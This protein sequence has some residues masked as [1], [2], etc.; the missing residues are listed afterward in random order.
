MASTPIRENLIQ[1]LSHSDESTR[2]ARMERIEWLAQHD[3][4]P[5]AYF[6]AVDT[7]SLVDEARTCFIYGLFVATV[8]LATS[9]VEHAL[10]DELNEQGLI[11]GR[12]TLDQMI[13]LAR[14]HLNLP[15][16][17]LE[18]ADRLRKVRNPFTHRRPETDPDTLGKRF[19]SEP[20]HPDAILEADAKLALRVMY[21]L[22]Q[23]TL[24]SPNVVTRNTP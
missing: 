13:K 3:F 9:F 17:L 21:E 4:R 7:I 6:G 22:F 10:A 16:D 23:S 11:K 1:A 24:R 5:A 8:L 15:N 14:S 12:L 20:A 19:L 18:Q 2:I